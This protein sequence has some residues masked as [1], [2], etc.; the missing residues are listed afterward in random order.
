M[1]KILVIDDEPAIVNL[2]Q[3]YLK[4][5]GYEVFTAIDGPSGLKAVR[6][7][8]PDLIVLDV[9]L[10]GMDGL[11]LLSRLRRESQVYVILL[12]ARTEE[13][14][15]IVGLSVGADDYVTKPFSPRELVARVKAAL[16]RIQTGS[17]SGAEG[18]VLVFR[19]MRMD[20]DARQVAVDD[21][22]IDLTT[23]EFDLLRVLAENRG[24]VLT[25]EQLLERVW[26]GSYFGEMRVVDVHLGHVRQKLGNPD[27]IV[28][29][30]GV[31]YRFDDEP[32]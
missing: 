6:A 23:S 13:T 1:T 16:R 28:T 7:F 8:K 10:P 21:Q 26:G 12:T 4:P 9:M 25:R 32:L 31:G 22:L 17:G 29:V 3:A 14:D 18:S 2:V 27:F 24:R 30:R 11:E 19:H 20:L 15:K 5:E